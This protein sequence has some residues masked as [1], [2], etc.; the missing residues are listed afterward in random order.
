MRNSFGGLPY[1]HGPVPK[2]LAG[3][4]ASLLLATG[5]TACGPASGRSS[6]RLGA[7]RAPT[8]GAEPALAAPGPHRAASARL[9]SATNKRRRRREHLV[10]PFQGALLEIGDSLGIDLGW[11]IDN[12]LTGTGHSLLTEAVGDTGLAEP[13]YY[14]WPGHLATYLSDYRPGLVVV[15]LGANDWENLY[16]S[17]VYA[18]FGSK[19]WQTVYG[20]RV[21]DI[22]DESTKAGARVLWVG[23]PPM[24]DPS[25]NSAMGHLNAVY[26]VQ[27]SEHG[28]GVAYMSSTTVL[29]TAEGEYYPGPPDDPWRT[30]DGVHI[31]TQGADVLALAVRKR[32]EALGWLAHKQ[33]RAT[34]PVAR[35]RGTA[36]RQPDGRVP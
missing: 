18:P 12:E 17:G 9:A 16:A 27:A 24:A 25:F 4:L 13:W 23:M 20:E 19:T 3:L 32:L 6:S 7:G 29:G 22:I 28:A 1:V 30:P 21:A 26:Q 14:D 35:G 11:G 33:H 34:T 36:R 10:R 31:T 8:V 15:F 5:A 2:V